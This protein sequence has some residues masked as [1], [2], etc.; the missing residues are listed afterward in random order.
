MFAVI[1]G[2][3]SALIGA[4]IVFVKFITNSWGPQ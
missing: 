1:V 3:V 4:G 2:V